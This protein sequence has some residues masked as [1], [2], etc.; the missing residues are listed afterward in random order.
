MI[1]TLIKVGIEGIY[2][3]I[4]KAIFDKRTANIT[5]NSEKLSAFPLKSG[6]RQ[7]CPLL[8]LLFNIVLEILVTAIRQK[9]KQRHPNWKGRSKT[10]FEDDMILYIENLKV[11]TKKLLE[12]I[13]EFSKVAGYKMNIQKSVDFLYTDN[14]LTEREI[15]ETIPFTI[16]SKRIKYLRINLTKKVK[17]VYSENYRTLMMEFENDKKK[18]KDI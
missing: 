12:L 8:P 14:E 16:T 1:K 9:E 15:K 3:N 4:I 5:L 17:Y 13:N 2:L 11:S 10:L 7:G 18:W 6:T